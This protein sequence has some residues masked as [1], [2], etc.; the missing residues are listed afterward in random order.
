[1][2]DCFAENKSFWLCAIACPIGGRADA[3]SF[4]REPDESDE[5]LPVVYECGIAG[6][7]RGKQAT[8]EADLARK[9]NPKEVV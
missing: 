7:S 3:H 6:G 4:S 1:M 5:P 9:E 8:G 2:C